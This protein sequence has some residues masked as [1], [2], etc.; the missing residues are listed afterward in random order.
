VGTSDLIA[1]AALA[2]ALAALGVS[3]YGI[4]RSNKTTSA[5][6]LVTLNEG[7]RQAWDRFLSDNVQDREYELAELMNLL[8]VACAAHE[9]GSITGNSRTLLFDYLDRVLRALIRNPYANEQIGSLLQSKDTY[10]FVRRF[11]KTKPRLSVTVPPAW[12]EAKE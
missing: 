8:E 11:L 7:F 4:R 1:S 3:W 10:K 2:V 5:A 12:Y 9:E 6:T